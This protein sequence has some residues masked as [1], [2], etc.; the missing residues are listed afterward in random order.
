[1]NTRFSKTIALFLG[2]GMLFGLAGCTAFDV[3]SAAGDTTTTTTAT[4]TTARAGETDTIT[5][6]GRTFALGD[7]TCRLGDDATALLAFLGEPLKVSGPREDAFYDG[8]STTYYY[9]HAAV[10][11]FRMKDQENAIIWHVFLGDGYYKINDIS[12]GDSYQE[13][14]GALTDYQ[15][16]GYAPTATAGKP[17]DF[18]PCLPSLPA[19]TWEYDSRGEY[20]MW[21]VFFG[22][23]QSAVLRIELSLLLS[24]FL[25]Q[26][27]L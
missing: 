15:C 2:I 7:S 26:Q 16:D 14:E 9:A 1:M 12:V 27:G 10:E 25:R 4:A 6:G 24:P 21:S 8:V 11:T 22:E 3:P 13:I 20:A 23:D 5:A 18:A 17:D 19:F